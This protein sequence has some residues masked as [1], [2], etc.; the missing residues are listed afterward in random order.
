MAERKTTTTT[1]T[2]ATTNTASETNILK[3]TEVENR[4]KNLFN[5]LGYNNIFPTIYDGLG[6]AYRTNPFIANDRIKRLSTSSRMAERDDIENS[7]LDIENNEELLR[8]ATRS[9]FN[10]A[11]PLYK[12]AYLYEGALAYHNYVYPVYVDKEEFKTPRFKSDEKFTDMWIKRLD[13]KRSFRRIVS[14]VLFE[15]KCFYA[16]RQKYNSTT[17]KEKVEY[18]L[19]QKLPSDYIKI[20]N[21]TDESYFG[22]SF[23]FFYFMTPGAS[24]DQFPPYFRDLYL[25][26]MNFVDE[27]TKF[28]L[29]LNEFNKKFT[30]EYN[31]RND[32]WAYWAELPTNLVWSFSF[33]EGD[34]LVT[35][36]FVSLL[37]MGSDLTNYSLLQQQLV[38][39]PLNSLILGEIATDSDTRKSGWSVDNFAVSPE[40]VSLF[41]NSI[42]STLANG[43]IAYKMTPSTKN[44]MFNIPNIPNGEVVYNEAMRGLVN[45]AGS[46]ALQSLS[47]KPSVSQTNNSKISEFR[48]VDRIYKQFE[49]FVNTVF[50]DMYENGDLKFNWRFKIFGNSFLEKEEF[51]ELEASLS[52]GQMQFFQRYLAY[53]DLTLLDSSVGIDYI[54]S[55]GIYDKFKPFLSA[56]NTNAAE[57]NNKEKKDNPKGGRPGIENP[58]NENTAASKNLGE[59]DARNE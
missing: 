43:N 1:K 27:K 13:P 59:S 55:T 7:L 14:E 51:S 19:L 41:E 28:P 5:R 38:S 49:H 44:Q 11:Y 8:G 23:N 39:A 58:D 20:T 16:L 24:L 53:K 29:T 33:T 18:A 34:A 57:L 52:L 26:L 22:I 35:S 40:A 47:E 6:S 32:T 37:L 15:G 36:P 17:E 25:E 12:L 3:T 56:F 21:L 31:S 45:T 48:Y 4:W 50:E 42:N 10:Q 30:V 2:S 54:E 46:G 9:I